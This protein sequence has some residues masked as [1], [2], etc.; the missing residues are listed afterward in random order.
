[1]DSQYHLL[2]NLCHLQHNNIIVMDDALNKRSARQLNYKDFVIMT[3]CCLVK[4]NSC[5]HVKEEKNAR[6]LPILRATP[7][8]LKKSFVMEDR[9]EKSSIFLLLL[10]GH[11]HF[12]PQCFALLLKDTKTHKNKGQK[13]GLSLTFK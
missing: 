5:T 10:F 13:K 11:P 2:G 3:R 1:M 4:K 7:S 12:S 8:A 6:C 9:K